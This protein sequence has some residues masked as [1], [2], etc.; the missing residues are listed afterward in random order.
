[1]SRRQDVC[2]HGGAFEVRATEATQVLA[3]QA[4]VGATALAG[5]DV[6]TPASVSLTQAVAVD[7]D[8]AKARRVTVSESK[9]RILGR[10]AHRDPREFSCKVQN[11][12]VYCV[13]SLGAV[14][15]GDIVTQSRGS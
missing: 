4:D 11:Y 7:Y 9:T 15:R 8:T 1:M 14:R 2:K 12:D 10:R 6:D 3:C 13:P 5:T